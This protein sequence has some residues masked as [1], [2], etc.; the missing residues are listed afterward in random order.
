MTLREYADANS[1]GCSYA[2]RAIRAKAL[3]VSAAPSVPKLHIAFCCCGDPECE[4]PFAA[5]AAPPE[6]EGK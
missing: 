3:P 4:I 2:A 6:G 5:R 1:W